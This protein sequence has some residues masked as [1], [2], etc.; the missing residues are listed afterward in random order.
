MIIQDISNSNNLVQEVLNSLSSQNLPHFWLGTHDYN[1]IWNLQKEIHAKVSTSSSL[2]VV[3]YLEHTNVY[4]LGKNSDSNHILPS[5]PENVVVVLTD[6]GGDVTYHGPG[7]LVGYPIINLKQYNKS[8]SW[9]MRS[10]EDILINTLH[11]IGIKASVKDGLTGVWVD[12]EKICAMGVRMAR[13]TSMH[14]F[15]L[16]VNTNLSYYNGLI[17]CGIFEYGITSIQKLTNSSLSV[18]EIADIVAMYC[19]NFF[20]EYK[21]NE[22]K[23]MEENEV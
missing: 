21:I 15:A 6:R 13:W 1:V 4:T 9:Y 12:D 17:P 7:Q 2:G 5:K 14:G 8:V 20:N 3:I 16:N 11:S 19:D 18:Y 23:M 10:L 22:Y